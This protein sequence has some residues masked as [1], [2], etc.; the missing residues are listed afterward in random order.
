[1]SHMI[2]Q[3]RVE[4]FGRDCLGNITGYRVYQGHGQQRTVAG[5]FCGNIYAPG[6]FDHA[7]TQAESLAASLN[8]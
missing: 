2:E 4:P 6:S 8:A 3:A 5:Q 1:M 7:R